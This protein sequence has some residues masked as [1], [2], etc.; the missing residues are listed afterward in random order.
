MMHRDRQSTRV[1]LDSIPLRD[2]VAIRQ[3]PKVLDKIISNMIL[4]HNFVAVVAILLKSGGEW[5][6]K[7]NNGIGVEEAI[8][9]NIMR[10][11]ERNSGKLT[12]SIGIKTVKPITERLTMKRTQMG[13][14][15]V[16]MQGKAGSLIKKNLI[17]FR[18][19]LGDSKRSGRGTSERLTECSMNSTLNI[20]SN[21]RDNF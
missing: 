1:V 11:M 17:S 18:K 14:G 10:E 21:S 8:P 2:L 5:R 16:Q 3:A 4:S 13:S 19:I 20:F 12:T 7:A 15:L 6:G 9:I